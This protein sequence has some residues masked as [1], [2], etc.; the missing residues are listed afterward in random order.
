MRPSRIIGIIVVLALAAGGYAWYQARNGDGGPRYR[1]ARVERGPLQAVVVASGTLNAV[2][3]VQVGSQIS[4]QVKEIYADF[5][6]PVKKDQIIARIDPSTYE[7]RVSQASADVEA[8]KSAVAV[9]RSQFAAQMAEAGRVKVNLADAQRDYERKKMLVAKNFISP[10]DR[11]KAKTLLDATREQLKSVEAQIK[12]S[13]AQIGSALAAVKQREALLKQ[14]QVDLERTIIR[15]PVDGTV[16]LRNVDAGQTVAASLQAP[17]LFTIAQDLRDMQVEAAIDEADVGRLKVG[18]T[19][20]FT[21][22]AFPRRSFSG[23]IRQIRKS[24]QN[25]QNVVSYT[26]VISAANP[27]LALLPGMTANVRV[28]VDQRDNALK[29]P[30]AA[31]RF[32]PPGASE[33]APAAAAAAPQARAQAAQE[34]RERLASARSS[35]TRRRRRSWSRSTPTRGRASPS[36]ARSRARPSAGACSSASAPKCAP[37]SARCSAREQKAAYE[38]IAGARDARGAAASGRVWILAQGEP[39]AVDLRLGLSDGTSTEVLSGPLKEGDEVVVGLLEARS[40]GPSRAAHAPVLM[41]DALIHTRG[42]VKVY[43]VGDNTIR[44]LDEVE[45]GDRARRVRGGDGSLG[46]RQVHLHE[47]A[48]LPRPARPRASTCWRDGACPSSAGDELAE[49]RNRNIGFVFQS[50]NLLPRTA[51]L[52]NVELPLFTPASR[53]TSGTSG[54]SACS[55]GSA[56]ASAL[57]HQ[58]AQL[59][60]GQQQRVAIARALVTQPVLILADEPTGA[61]DSRTSLE[62]MALFQDLNA[63]GMTVVLVTHEPDV[64]RFAR[65]VLRFLDGRLVGDVTRRPRMPARSSRGA[66]RVMKLGALLRIALRALAANKLRSALTMLGIIIGV[67]AVIVMIAVGAGAQARVAEQIRALGSNL[68]LILSGARTQGGVRLSVGSTYTITEDDAIA[69]NRE[70]PEAIAAPA[71][72]GGAQVIWGNANWATQ[73]YGTTPE[74]L[75]VR[76]WPLAEGRGFEAAEMSGAGKVCIVGQTVVKQ[77]FGGADPLGQVIRIKRVP[78]TVVG[79]LSA[80]GQ[81]MMGTDQDD[82]IIVPIGTAR[83]RV[84]GRANIAAQRSVSVIWVKAARG[85][86]HQAGRGRG[87]RAAAPAPSPAAGRRR[88]LFAAQPG[89]HHGRAGSLEPRARAAAGGGGVRVAGGGR[90]RHHEH[91]AGVGDRAYARNRAAHGARRAHARHSRAVPGRGRDAFAHRRPGRRAARRRRID[92]H[93]ER[94]RLEHRALGPLDPARGRLRRRD[95][96]VL[97]LLSCAQGGS[98]QPRR[99]PAL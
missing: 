3:T 56:W 51:A 17:V 90:H 98:A 6:T 16:I 62:I 96:R 68:L 41:P 80:K 95:R 7:L 49:V 55:P 69:I 28:V 10:S 31:L 93:R 20:T 40:E 74:Y 83:N 5:N 1:M 82:I 86:R 61:L 39:Q 70:I 25:V 32:R 99:S 9:A 37:R 67:A 27:D 12:V 52:E 43:T 29:L 91:H 79:V 87:A 75:E 23:E 21:V 84:L 47:S 50:F 42:L 19:A 38:K 54:R 14:A 18:Q 65:R 76:E 2:T 30:N 81:S 94:R 33:P 4:G 78:F 34:Q 72:R 88:R 36:C 85:L 77:L 73:I 59:S 8:A 92:R 22:D 45:R 89:R 63:S 35:S 46:L 58:P 44:A 64:A 13:Q 66:G 60:G 97:R 53:R 48:R 24:P 26:V 71:L 15:A 57:Q 11:D